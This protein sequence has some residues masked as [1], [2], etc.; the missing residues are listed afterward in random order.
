MLSLFS[1]IAAGMTINANICMQVSRGV[2]A[3]GGCLL[4]W[5]VCCTGRGS[6]PRGVPGGDPPGR[7]LQWGRYCIL[8][9]Q[10][11]SC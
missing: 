11:H 8:H 7:L 10:S 3:A 1:C 5:G 4:L 2:P 9:C 6:A